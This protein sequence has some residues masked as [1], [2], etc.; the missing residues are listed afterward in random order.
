MKALEIYK[1]TFNNDFMVNRELNFSATRNDS[2][3]VLICLVGSYWDQVVE[4]NFSSINF[5]K[6]LKVVSYTAS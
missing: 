6:L 1:F 2:G 5:D 3:H 4:I